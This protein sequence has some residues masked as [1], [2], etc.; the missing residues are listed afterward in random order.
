MNAAF[1]VALMQRFPDRSIVPSIDLIKCRHLP[2]MIWISGLLIWFGTAPYGGDGLLM[3]YGVLF[4]WIYLRFFM[5][6]PD[7]NI[8]GD[9]RNEFEI[10]EF[11]PDVYTLRYVAI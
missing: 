7:T 10:A 9:L 3:F 8:I 1:A 6:D 2:M 5:V 4:S 11:F